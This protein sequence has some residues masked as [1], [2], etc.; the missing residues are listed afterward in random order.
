MYWWNHSIISKGG[1]TIKFNIVP[2]DEIPVFLTNGKCVYSILLIMFTS[3]IIHRHI[4]SIES[5]GY[6]KI[7]TRR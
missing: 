7:V 1:S 3:D 5:D 4:Y 2:L 6:L